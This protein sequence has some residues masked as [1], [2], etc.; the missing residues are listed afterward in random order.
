MTNP[1]SQQE[2]EPRQQNLNQF[3]LRNTVPLAQNSKEEEEEERKQ[4]SMS[5]PPD[6]RTSEKPKRYVTKCEIPM[7]DPTQDQSGKPPL[8]PKTSNASINE[9]AQKQSQPN[10]RV[11]PIQVEGRDEPVINTNID[12]SANFA[13]ERFGDPV[14]EGRLPRDFGS[15]RQHSPRFA[16][17]ERTPPQPQ[18]QPHP[19]AHP[20][21]Q[22]TQVPHP[23]PPPTDETDS[24][25]KPQ[26]PKPETLKDP[27]TKVQF[28]QK[29]VEELLKEV[30]AFEGTSRKDKQYMILDELLTRKLI[31]LD[32]I[33][34]E[35][36]ENI[37]QAR[38]DTIRSIQ[39]CISML[40]SKVPVVESSNENDEGRAEEMKTEEAASAAAPV[41]QPMEVDQSKQTEDQNKQTMEV[42][43]TKNDATSEEE[44][45]AK[46]EKIDA[47]ESKEEQT[48]EI[49]PEKPA[50]E[51]S[52][53][54]K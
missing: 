46:K 22:Q 7:H 40:E 20:Q 37:R 41:E 27:L 38:K 49:E 3:G 14:F 25:P 13:G 17:R 2:D 33:D 11:I 50:Q 42:D 48:M 51:Q 23:Q 34:T 10:V 19:Q 47:K 21:P 12:S 54:V 8:A 53:E 43:Q 28:I 45:L 6:N 9:P 52:D 24:R 31:S 4:R 39:R 30:E 1:P 36:K 18:P 5:A 35:G 32:D 29:E 15:Y 44:P 16:K 26:P